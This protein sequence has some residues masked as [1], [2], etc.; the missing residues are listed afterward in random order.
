MAADV[1]SA[2]VE[3]RTALHCAAFEK[4]VEA[5]KLLLRH[6]AS[7]DVCTVHRRT[8]LHF[9]CIVGDDATCQALLDAGASADVQDFQ[10]NTPVHYAA[11][12]STLVLRIEYTDILK[13]LLAKNP[14]LSIKN[15]RGNTAVDSN[16]SKVVVS[17]FWSYLS[18]TKTSSSSEGGKD[19]AEERKLE[20][21][22]GAVDFG[23]I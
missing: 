15:K 8:P 23:L 6:G 17:V 5:A 18:G 20:R 12:Y 10:G 22:Q 3:N 4:K 16:K 11:F 13:L 14:D 9:A 7:A 1:N 21:L 2:N 19:L